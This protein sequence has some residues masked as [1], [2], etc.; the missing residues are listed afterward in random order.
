MQLPKRRTRCSPASPS[1]RATAS[2][3]AAAGATC[4]PRS[5]ASST[6]WP[7]AVRLDSEG[8]EKL[9][10]QTQAG[11]DEIVITGGSAEVD[12]GTGTDRMTGP[13]SGGLWNV[14]G[15]GIGNEPHQ[16]E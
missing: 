1:H 10:V 3:S 16:L 12:G 2:I 11:N 15:S 7:Q 14:T 8:V 4:R 5:S 13:N 6:T 9:R